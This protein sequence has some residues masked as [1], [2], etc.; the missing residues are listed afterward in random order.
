MKIV[1]DILKSL[2][3][4]L[5]LCVGIILMLRSISP[6]LSFK[7]D[8]GFLQVKQEYVGLPLWRTAFYIHVFFSVFTLAA[9]LTQFSTYFLDHFRKR[10]RQIGKLYVFNILCINFPTG[11]IL[12]LC[13][14]G[15]WH[16]KLAF[17][18]LD[19]LWFWYTL[20]GFA[21]ARKRNIRRHEEFMTRS[22]AL[23]FSAITLRSW[24][25][26]L[27]ATTDL[28]YDTIYM[29]E[30]WLGFVPNLLVAEW[31]IYKRRTLTSKINIAQYQIKDDPVA[32][33][34]KQ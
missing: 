12:A 7:S 26:I 14:N 6:H 23:T 30:A 22:F 25:V 2:V 17:V 1:L 18:I 20:K 3:I 31:L 33:E 11:M 16:T 19:C 24:K 13:A 4:Y 8:V 15:A 10:H 21:E 27:A 34:K 9:G 32:T 29:M 5:V 28:D